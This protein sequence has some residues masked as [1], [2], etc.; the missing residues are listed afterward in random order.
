M[1]CEADGS[2]RPSHNSLSVL[3]ATHTGFLRLAHTHFLCGF[4]PACSLLYGLVHKEATTW[5]LVAAHEFWRQLI[6]SHCFSSS[7]SSHMIRK[8]MKW[9][10]NTGR[11]NEVVGAW[12]ALCGRG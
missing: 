9:E 10:K 2:G 1:P 4:G 7:A 5:G 11:G 6:P 12:P 8:I 3:E